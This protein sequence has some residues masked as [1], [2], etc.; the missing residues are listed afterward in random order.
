MLST[1][2]ISDIKTVFTSTIV[3]IGDVFIS[4]SVAVIT[5]SSVMIAQGLQG[6][7]DLITTLFLLLGVKRSKRKAT[8]AHPFGYG[9]ELFFWVLISSLLAFLFSGGL[10]I[11]LAIQQI[12]EAVP[13]DYIY[14]A[15][16]ALI[17]GLFT[18]GYSLSNSIRRLAQSRKNQSLFKYIRH[19]SLI[20]TKMTLLVDL[21][22][23]LSALF[24]IVA[25]VLYLL[26]GNPVFDGVGALII[27]LLTATGAL[28]VIID[29]HDLI[30]GRT[31]PAAVIESIRK[32]TEKVHGVNEL[33]DIHA[34]SVGSGQFLVILEVHFKDGFTT[35]E[36]EKITDRI[37]EEVAQAEPQ[38][39]TVQVEAETP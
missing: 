39:T 27:G 9:R 26:T 15:L 30:I 36:I 16:V 24:G 20:E 5:G 2:P 18:N 4:L 14:L 19:S 38:I 25:L 35:D 10:A 31:P 13:I 11:F 12:I 1:K 17:F 32:T 34:T 28:Y 37:K 29:L 8:S 23:T 7:A 33:L 6:L 3:S 21:M 22:G